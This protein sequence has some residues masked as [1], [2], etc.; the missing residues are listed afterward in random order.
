[1]F[2]HNLSVGSRIASSVRLKLA[3][4][5]TVNSFLAGAMELAICSAPDVFNYGYRFGHHVVWK[6][7]IVYRDF[8]VLSK[9]YI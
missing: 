8:P 3:N 1:M 6:S 4:V 9:L 7:L 2:T 5:Y